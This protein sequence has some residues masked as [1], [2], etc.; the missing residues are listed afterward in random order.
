EEAIDILEEKKHTLEQ[1]IL[2]II[3]DNLK[4]LKKYEEKLVESDMSLAIDSDLNTVKEYQDEISDLINEAKYNQAWDKLESLESFINEISKP[5]TDYNV[6]VKQYDIT[7]YPT[8]RVYLEVTDDTGNFIDNLDKDDFYV[9]V[10]RKIDD[11]FKRQDII[12]AVKIN[13]NEGISLGLVADISGSMGDKLIQVQ[14]G[15]TN[16]IETVQ[17]SKGDEVELTEFSDSAYV[18]K[19][20][21]NNS[22]D[23]LSAINMMSTQGSTR[24]Y[25][26]LISEIER[27]H[28]RSNAKCIIGFTDGLDNVS[29]YS[30][31]DVIRYANT[32]QIPIFLIGIGSDCD[33]S[34]L[35]NIAESTGGIY[36]NINDIDSLEEIYS[37]I[38]K[39]EKEVYLLEYTICDEDNFEDDCYSDIYIRTQD[40]HGGYVDNFTFVPNEFFS[41]MYNKFLIAGIDCQTK[42]E[43]NLLDSG[44]IV[45]DKKAYKDKDC[46]AYQ[47][48]SAIDNGGVGS[49]NSS[50]FE[51]LVYYDVI[52]VEKEKDGYVLYGVANYD[53]SK[54]K[55]YSAIKNDL[56]K[57]MINTYYGD[58]IDKNQEFWIE[59]NITNYEKLT[60]IKDE[61]GKWKFNKRTYEREDGGKPYFT[62]EVYNVIMQ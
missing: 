41:L 17:F 13:E 55:K 20:F 11:E 10:G 21:T 51:V 43:R 47:S 18:C 40:H 33:E 27:I 9:N 62:S 4:Q 37:S 23:I 29:V 57:N 34:T 42:G 61:D 26:T 53:I 30:A 38:Y 1:L 16:F 15:M 19:S 32:Y 59:E 24:L 2:D 56:E 44:L 39:Q 58:E 7:N 54:I 52:R 8:I 36:H 28:T 6:V 45:T 22:S 12:K 49:N 35:K 14:Q 3:D 46:I 48:Q 31:Q 50:V 60:L 25:D 5:L